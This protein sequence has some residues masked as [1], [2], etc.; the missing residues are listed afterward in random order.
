MGDEG[1]ANPRSEAGAAGPVGPDLRAQQDVLSLFE[2]VEGSCL[3]SF[4]AGAADRVVDERVAEV[5]H[6][7]CLGDHSAGG[8]EGMRAEDESGLAVLL[9]ADPVVH[10]AR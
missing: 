2:G 3:E 4:G 10:T 1:P 6:A 9:E 7:E 5:G 8:I